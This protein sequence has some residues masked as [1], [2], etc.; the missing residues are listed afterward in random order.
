MNTETTFTTAMH[1]LVEDFIAACEASDELE[2]LQERIHDE[3]TLVW[4]ELYEF[5]V[6]I[7]EYYDI[8]GEDELDMAMELLIRQ[9]GN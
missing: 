5:M 9:L 7:N 4:F 3:R 6:E 8:S 2:E 1:N